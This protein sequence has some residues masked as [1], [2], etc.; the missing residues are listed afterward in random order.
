MICSLYLNGLNFIGLRLIFVLCE[1]IQLI[2]GDN[3]SFF[4][5]I[6]REIWSNCWDDFVKVLQGEME[7]FIVY[8]VIGNLIVCSISFIFYI[9]YGVW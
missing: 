7:G 3:I 4:E 1:L 6:G 9:V 8:I 5:I 2:K